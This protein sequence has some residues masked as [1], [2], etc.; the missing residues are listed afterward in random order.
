MAHSCFPINVGGRLVA[1]CT[2]HWMEPL[3]MPAR[4]YQQS[5]P[6]ADWPPV[7]IDGQRKRRAR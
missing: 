3:A 2:Q 1:S 7:G 5:A 6:P 4:A